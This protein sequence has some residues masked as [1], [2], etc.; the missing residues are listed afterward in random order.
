M[1]DNALLNA[2][3]RIVEIDNRIN[4]LNSDI[5]DIYKKIE[6]LTAEREKLNTFVVVWHELAGLPTPPMAND[7]VDKQAKS[8]KIRLVRPK[9]PDRSV[10]VDAVLEIIRENGRPMSRSAL[11][12][13]LTKRNIIIQGKD[14]DM[15][16]STMLWRSQDRVVRL[17]PYGYWD[18]EQSYPE[19]DYVSNLVD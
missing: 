9:N 18:A 14:P 15:V 5:S 16:L 4:Q 12:N 8:L 3:Q 19:A 6:T 7:S 2:E 13:A 17:P 11:F 1:T 10:V